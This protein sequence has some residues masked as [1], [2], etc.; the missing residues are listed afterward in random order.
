MFLDVYTDILGY[1]FWI[2]LFIAMLS[3]WLSMRSLQHARLRLIEFMERKYGSRVITMIHRQ[4]KIGL[5]G[6]PIYRYID[7]EDSEAIIRAIR[8]TP[9]N[10]PI[11]LILHTPGGLVLAASQIAKALKA[12]PAKKVVVVPH[13]AMSGGTLIALAADEI[14]MDP[15]AVLGPLDPQLG[16]PGGTYFPAPSILRAVEIKGKDKVDDQTLI[17]ADMAEKAIRQV[18]ELVIELIR[19]KVGEERAQQIADR[20][21]SGYYTHDYPITVEELRE[22]GL[23]VSIDVP[24]EVYELMMLYPQART[25]RPGIE[26]LPYPIVPRPTTRET[27]SEIV[28]P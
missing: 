6:V 18:K 1:L 20:L 25:N 26:Y 4:E 22:M 2:L 28:F 3:P 10:M 16:G 19:D 7:I 17:L 8:T 15:N 13:Y 24:P 9:P 5:L 27:R 11:M 14:I 12:H 23:K 21:V